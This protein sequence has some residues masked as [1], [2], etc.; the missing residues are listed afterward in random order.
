ME[1]VLQ[2]WK[3]SDIIF[4]SFSFSL[5]QIIFLGTYFVFR[6]NGETQSCEGLTYCLVVFSVSVRAPA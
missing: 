2:I 6:L 4:C 1:T 3:L 5:K